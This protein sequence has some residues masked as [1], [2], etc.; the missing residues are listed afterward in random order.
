MRRHLIPALAV[1]AAGAVLVCLPLL[2][3]GEEYGHA[4]PPHHM[5][6]HARHAG[7]HGLHGIFEALELTDEQ[8]ESIHEVLMEA[9]QGSLK[10][11]E[12]ASREARQALDE[13]IHDFSASERDVRKAAQEFGRRAA[14]LAVE[15]HRLAT[16]VEQMLMP[17][18]REKLR[19]LI[20]ARDGGARYGS[21]R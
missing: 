6:Q 2:A 8:K 14:D 15:Q 17:E 9:Y 19:A 4:G 13:T 18:Q 3:G 20:A 11:L 16:T 5:D 10:E 7:G 21:A 12:E 1:F